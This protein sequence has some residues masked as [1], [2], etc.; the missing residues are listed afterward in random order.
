[1]NS[2][3]EEVYRETNNLI[4]DSYSNK[5]ETAIGKTSVDWLKDKTEKYCQERSLFLAIRDAVSIIDGDD[6]KRTKEG[7]PDILKEALSI[8]FDTNIGHDYIE[9]YEA[10]YEEYHKVENKIPFGLN[11][12]NKITGGGIPTKSMLVWVA[13]TG[14]G[15]T[16]LMTWSTTELLLAG[17]NVLYVSCEMAETRIAERMDAA[18]MDVAV[19]DLKT[20]PKD[21]YAKKIE[22]IKKQNIGKIIVKEYPPASISA[23]NIR[24][25]LEELKNKKDFKPDVLVIDYLNLMLSSRFTSGRENSYTLMKAVAE[26]IRSLAIEYD[27]LLMTATQTNRDGQNASDFELNDV[28]ESHGI[29]M[30]ADI[31]IGAISTEELE[32]MGR[33]KL[34]QLKN[35]FGPLYPHNI[36]AVGCDR[37]KM[38]LYNVENSSTSADVAPAIAAVPNKEKPAGMA[39]FKF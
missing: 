16:L 20:M 36:E 3:G 14:V 11:W 10:R 37:P 1:L 12:I 4:V 15:K 22:N 8:S 38:K 32:R 19:D 23:S 2:I 7:I 9:D 21:L 27:L 30:T 6:K 35:R 31:M 5:M 18:L 13:P 26:E 29:S 25:L 24:F 33:L 34:K 39:K 17:K 28:S